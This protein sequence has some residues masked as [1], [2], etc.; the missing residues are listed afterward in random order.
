M[1]DLHDSAMGVNQLVSWPQAKLVDRDL[2]AYLTD[3]VC[4]PFEKPTG[5][6][7][8]AFFN[9]PFGALERMSQSVVDA[10]EFSYAW[11]KTLFTIEC[12]AEAKDQK[13]KI[14]CLVESG[15]GD[16]ELE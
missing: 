15:E 4:A 9:C 8:C 5:D 10:F 16:L 12:Q 6:T 13:G 1:L 3:R 2:L 11:L 7:L 14:R